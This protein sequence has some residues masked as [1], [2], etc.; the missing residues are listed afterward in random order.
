MYAC[1]E[2]CWRRRTFNANLGVVFDVAEI[3]GGYARVRR[4]LSDVGQLQDVLTDRHA[5]LRRQLYRSEPPLDVRH[6]RADG[7][8][9]QIDGATRRHLRALRQNGEMWRHTPNCNT[10]DEKNATRRGKI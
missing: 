8:A 4:R 7:N 1:D 10:Y 3:G 5:V 2:R 9:R 6:R